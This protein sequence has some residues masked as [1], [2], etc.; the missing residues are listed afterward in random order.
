MVSGLNQFRK[1]NRLSKPAE[2]KALFTN[3][4][5]RQLLPFM[6]LAKRNDL[7]EARLGLAI[8]K[9]HVPLA[10]QRNSLKRLIRES[11]REHKK[12]FI[13]WDVVVVTKRKVDMTSLNQLPVLLRRYWESVGQ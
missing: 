5:R 12:I 11:F 9:K 10:T 13:G 7:D 8:S 4:K 6:F 3:G 1:T 2:F